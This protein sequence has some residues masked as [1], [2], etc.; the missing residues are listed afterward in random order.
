MMPKTGVR[1]Q[2]EDDNLAGQDVIRAD[3]RAFA[4][5]S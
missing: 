5:D 1:A 2:S 4:K 3:Y